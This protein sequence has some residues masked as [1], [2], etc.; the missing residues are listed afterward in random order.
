MSLKVL[1]NGHLVS[2]S[3]DDTMNIWNPCLEGDNFVRAIQEHG[4]TYWAV[5]LFCVLSNDFLVTCSLHREFQE[6]CVLMVHDPTDGTKTNSIPTG[7]KDALSLLVLSNDQ[8]VI[9]FMNG[10]IK[11]FDLNGGETRAIDQAHESHVFSLFQLSNG[12][13]VSSGWDGEI[14]IK[15]WDLADLS[16]FQ[17]IQTDHNMD[18]RSIDVS[19]DEAFLATGSDDLRIKIWPLH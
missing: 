1:K 14:I 17:T 10:S 12:N 7:Q 3:T 2:Y 4:N 8:V 18:I 6:E 19:K 9:G 13:L 11:I 15:V 5:P 16:L